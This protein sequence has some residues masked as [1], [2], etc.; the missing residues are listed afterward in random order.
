[1]LFEASLTLSFHL[2]HLIKIPEH[3]INELIKDIR[4]K[5]YDLLQ[6][7]FLSSTQEKID[8]TIH[9]E[10]KPI[11][12]PEGAYAINRTVGT[13]NFKKMGVEAFA[14]RRGNKRFL[15][16]R[17]NIKIHANDVIILYGT[18]NALEQA[19]TILLEG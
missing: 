8:S 17:K 3:R 11:A 4:N 14:I 15:K 6:K 7:V 5:D 10:L 19:E 16:P 12:I 2:L 9:E 18:P 1:E 13:F